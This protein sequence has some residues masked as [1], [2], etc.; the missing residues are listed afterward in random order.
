MMNALL[1]I[2]KQTKIMI[3]N[4]IYRY[5]WIR[6]IRKQGQESPKNSAMHT[7]TNVHTTLAGEGL[8][9]SGRK[10]VR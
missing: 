5:G 10:E 4:A 3:I 2:K 1:L 6:N 9:K 8:K 7:H